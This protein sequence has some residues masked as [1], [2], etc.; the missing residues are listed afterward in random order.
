MDP[1]QRPTTTARLVQLALIPKAKQL[2]A[3]KYGRVPPVIPEPPP[4]PESLTAEK[5]PTFHQAVSRWKA[6]RAPAP[7]TAID[8]EHRI[9]E[10]RAYLGH[11]C[12]AQLTAQQV[13][14][15]R[16]ELITHSS[17]NTVRRKLALVRAVLQAVAADGMPIEHQVIERLTAK[18]MRESGGTQRQRRPF[19]HE[20]AA[21]L[22][23]LSRKQQG[24]RP[25]NHWTFPLGL[26]LGYRLEEL[27]G[28]RGED[29]CEI[30]G[31]WAVVIQPAEDRRL[32]TD[33]S[34]RKTP[35]PEALIGERF[36]AW[37]QQ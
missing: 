26:S 19:T 10:F 32:K 12:L 27:A 5:G 7:K 24:P 21:L 25:F 17:I 14:D 6:L 31:I 30:D 20:E 35:I 11:D 9:E 28:R 1:L 29:I 37:A 18:G 3:L 4:P 13:S 15:W 36:I 23:R 8:A 2:E 22:R 34:A 33:S 16:A